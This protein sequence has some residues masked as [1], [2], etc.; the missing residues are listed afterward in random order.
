M[1]E[2]EQ[3]RGAGTTGPSSRVVPILAGFAALAVV[4]VAVIN[5]WLRDRS[6]SANVAAP[7]AV[8]A[9]VTEV[10]PATEA[11]GASVGLVIPPAN[12]LTPLPEPA[13]GAASGSL[14][15]TD[16]WVNPA[17]VGHPFGDT[18]NGVLT[19]RGNP[20][21]TYYGQGPVPNDPK[22]VWRFGEGEE[23][24]SLTTVPPE[25][26]LW[27]GTGW[28]GQPAIFDY[29]GNRWVVVGSY[30]P[31]VHFLNA[32]DGTRLRPDFPVG[33]LIKGSVSVDPD[34]FPL[35][36]VGSRDGFF[37]V[38]AFDR[39]TPVELWRLS[40]TDV[41]P[42]L[43]NDDW[44][45]ASLV[46]DDFLFIGG[47]NSQWHAVRLNRSIGPDGLVQVAPEIVFHSPGW[48]D[49]LLVDVGDQ[50]VSIES[51]I[52][53]IGDRL[54]FA[55]SGGLVQAWDI[56]GLRTGAGVPERVFRFWTGDDT[57]STIVLDGDGSI[58]VGS[59]WERGLYRAQEL[60]QFM[61]LD[62]SQPDDPVVWSHKFQRDLPDG[63]W[64]TAALDRDVV[65][66]PTH[67]GDLYAFDAE[68]GEVRWSKQLTG[69]VWSSPVVVDE[70]LIQADC[71]GVIHAYDVS[72]TTVEPPELW[73]VQLPWCVE[74]T[75]AVFDGL[76]VVGHRHGEVIAMAD[77]SG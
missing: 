64:A 68:T 74:S 2:Q 42:T 23:L 11:P 67:F 61:K 6:T 53:V 62:P 31:A 38:V 32:L 30:A 18:V 58:Y 14:G 40:A 4:A 75:P 43:W 9:Q 20:T 28:T 37:R 60:G 59:E 44:D 29:D 33:D 46:I 63:V 50:N 34:G 7:A 51:S 77:P 54:W 16:S 35:V 49:Q 5:V 52:S 57:D 36:Y 3:T 45:S 41:S 17:S 1:S 25:T 72:D 56:S 24:C 10:A 15:G 71:A 66:V 55:N 70:V 13:G 19:F 47:E 69:P 39:D 48:D 26:S 21:R 76:I 8:E 27:C 12:A 73:V 65:Y 22:I